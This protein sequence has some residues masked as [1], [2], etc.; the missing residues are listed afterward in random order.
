MKR[1][2][3]PRTPHTNNNPRTCNLTPNNL[4][5][6]IPPCKGTV[7]REALAQSQ[8]CS[9]PNMLLWIIL[10]LNVS[11]YRFLQ[12]EYGWDLYLKASSV[13]ANLMFCLMFAARMVHD[14]SA[15][16]SSR[17]GVSAIHPVAGPVWS[18]P[19]SMLYFSLNGDIFSMK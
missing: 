19:H 9:G 12:L 11:R 1:I 17:P 5:S 3:V 6:K 8:Q 13:H 14:H 4:S 16:Q 10:P 18:L 7:D 2:N 15:P